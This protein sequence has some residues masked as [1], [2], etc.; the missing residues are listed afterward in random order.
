MKMQSIFPFSLTKEEN[1]E[2]Q[3]LLAATSD[4]ENECWWQGEGSERTWVLVDIIKLL[5][6]FC[7]EPSL[8]LVFQLESLQIY[9]LFNPL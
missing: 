8:P 3:L 7:L 9:L 5:M 4:H 1:R 6:A 2:P